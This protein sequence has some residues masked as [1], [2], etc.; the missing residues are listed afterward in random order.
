M[1]IGN[2]DLEKEVYI[3]AEVG[4]NHN[5]DPDVACELVKQAAYAGANAVKFQ[6][7]NAHLLV[8]PSV[9][10]VPIVKKHYDTQ[11]ER[12]KSLELD[13]STYERIMKL[14]NELQIDFMTT[15]FDVELLKEF[16]DDM[17]AIK[18]SSGDLTYH[19]L[20]L[21]AAVYNKPII[22]STGMSE[23]NEINQ[24]LKLI[25]NSQVILLHCVSIYPLPDE[26][27]NLLAIT[28]MQNKW[29][30]IMIGYSDHSIGEEACLAAVGLGAKVIE[31][32][33]TMDVSQVPGDHILSLD[34]SQM[35]SM[36]EK[37]RR[38][39]VMFGKGE[40]V[41][42]LRENSM[43]RMMRRGIY[44]ANDLPKGHVI[45]ANDCLIIRPSSEYAANNID[46]L[47]GK[48]I[49]RGVKYLA[50]FTSEDIQEP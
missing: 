42:R 4:G 22:I 9:E 46:T 37:I 43:R 24:A 16:A 41:P 32:H 45:T 44:A 38:I 18:I 5:G 33:F 15:L 26:Q 48:R 25:K 13:A 29:P 20:I 6:T 40:K 14:C 12:F 31:K 35:K 49:E 19:D 50:P 3:I 27:V 2:T 17:P 8:H 30:D 10:P 11:L 39:Q 21:R 7:Y 36:V 34:P 28:T 47:I 23:I 1:R